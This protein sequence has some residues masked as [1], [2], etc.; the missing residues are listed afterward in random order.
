MSLKK[1][2]PKFLSF[3]LIMKCGLENLYLHLIPRI[4][5]TVDA[6]SLQ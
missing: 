6:A 5:H 4:M 1:T 2:D 3:K